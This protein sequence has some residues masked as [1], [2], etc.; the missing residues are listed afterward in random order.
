MIL[1]ASYGMVLIALGASRHTVQPHGVFLGHDGALTS[2]SFLRGRQGYEPRST[3]EADIAAMGTTTRCLTPPSAVSWEAML[4]GRRSEVG[5]D[6]PAM[7]C[8]TKIGRKSMMQQ[9]TG[10]RRVSTAWLRDQIRRGSFAHRGMKS[11]SWAIGRF[12]KPTLHPKQRGALRMMLKTFGDANELVPVCRTRVVRFHSTPTQLCSTC[13]PVA[14]LSKQVDELAV[15]CGRSAARPHEAPPAP[16][17]P[18]VVEED[19]RGVSVAAGMAFGRAPAQVFQSSTC[20]QH[21]RTHARA[22]S[23]IV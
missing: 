11:A 8:S 16:V 14:P 7:L 10:A 2:L 13:L 9:S 4:G 18:L 20:R 6:S 19:A 22:T 12:V 1:W 23:T 5:G 21:V 17:S 15:L 3:S